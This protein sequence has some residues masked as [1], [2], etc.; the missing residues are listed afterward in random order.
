MRSGL[1]ILAVGAFICFLALCTPP[2]PEAPPQLTA[3]QERGLKLYTQYCKNCHGSTGKLQLSGAA[4][5]AESTIDETQVAKIVLE[6]KKTMVGFKGMIS[7]E[8]A[9]KIAD[10]V[11][12][13]RK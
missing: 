9:D 1:S 8:D 3:D 12:L 2:A 7:N 5:L 6:G 11:M 10:Y 4:N 13:L